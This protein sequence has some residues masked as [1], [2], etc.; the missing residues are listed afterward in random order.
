MAGPEEVPPP[1]NAIEI[2]LR[3]QS[4]ASVVKMIGPDDSGKPPRALFFPR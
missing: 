2:R 3:Y 4:D 1:A